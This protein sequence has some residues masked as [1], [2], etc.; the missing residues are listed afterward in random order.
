MYPVG[1]DADSFGSK[2][3]NFRNIEA[4]VGGTS[5]RELFWINFPVPRN[6]AAN[7]KGND[8]I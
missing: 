8:F 3:C 7:K 1:A 2:T 5:S 4:A 6:M